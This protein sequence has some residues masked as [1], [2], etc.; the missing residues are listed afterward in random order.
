MFKRFSN[1]HL[2]ISLG[3]LV[4]LY[5]ISLLFGGSSQRSFDEN[6]IL[7]DTANVSRIEITASGEQP[8]SLQKE[9]GEWKVEVSEGNFVPIE[10]TP[11]LS[12]LGGIKK[13]S[14]R[15]LAAKSEDQWANFEVDESGLNLKI[16]QGEKK[17]ADIYAGKS[18][19]RP[20]G[21]MSYV[22]KEGEKETYMVATNLG[23]SFGKR[24]NDWRNK[25]LINGE[26]E[27]WNMLSFNY[28]GDS[29]FQLIK[30]PQNL[31]MYSDSSATNS[32]E[33]NTFLRILSLTKGIEFADQLPQGRPEMSLAVQS[34]TSTP[35]Q[36]S[37]FA[38]GRGGYLLTS[39]LNPGA[40]FDGEGL[41]DKIFVGPGKFTFDSGL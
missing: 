38:N 32:S 31:W 9:G 15:G 16:F 23:S 20:S 27:S 28:S 1:R 7:L 13:V 35:F 25:S 26:W 3:S 34:L 37:A 24:P 14:A 29:S 8:Y 11:F 5:L 33:V 6:L 12:I 19:Y 39:T 21:L 17:L 18:F 22:R 36:I 2:A 41:M 30:T 40:V 4:V 10:K